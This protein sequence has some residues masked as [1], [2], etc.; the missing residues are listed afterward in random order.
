MQ[1]IIQNNKYNIFN[2]FIYLFIQLDNAQNE[3]DRFEEQ[4]KQLHIRVDE[5]QEKLNRLDDMN[6]STKKFK[7]EKIHRTLNE[8]END[9]KTK[10]AKLEKKLMELKVINEDN[11]V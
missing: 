11:K 5:L 9:Y 7:P 3:R 8:V 10:L 1:Q 6:A 2:S 4:Y